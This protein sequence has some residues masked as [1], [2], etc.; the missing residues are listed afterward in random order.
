MTLTELSEFAELCN[1]MNYLQAAENLYISQST[2]SRHVQ[3]MEK[4]L[5]VPLFVRN[6]RHMALTEEGACLLSY[7]GRINRLWDN[8]R[9][10]LGHVRK[11]GSRHEIVIGFGGMMAPYNLNSLFSDYQRSHPDIVIRL[12]KP[13][14]GDLSLLDEGK[15]DFILYGKGKLPESRY[16]S[17]CVLKDY[18]TAVVSQEHLLADLKE[19][20]ISALSSYTLALTGQFY[21]PGSVFMAACREAGFEPAFRPSDGTDLI[22]RASLSHEISIMASRPAAYV[23]D[24]TVSIAAITPRIMI[25]ADLVCLRE[26][27]KREEIRMFMQYL[28]SDPVQRKV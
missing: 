25:R 1:T 8:C 22:D 15:C 21:E 12:L 28:A 4:E 3:A 6:K 17:V 20:P 9:E 18:L 19:I 5:G 11:Q 23:A 16:A 10:E 26:S 24:E 14:I 13:R 7:A 27:L 2:L